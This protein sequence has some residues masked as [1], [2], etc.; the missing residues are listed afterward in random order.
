MIDAVG[1]IEGTLVNPESGKHFILTGAQKAF[2]RRAFEVAPDG[3]LKY[4]ELIFSAPKKTGK[5]AF[6]AFV[7]L[8]VVCVLGGRFAEGI[9]CANDEEQ[10]QGRVF[11]A[12][13]RITEASPTLKGDATITAS[14]ITFASTGS[15]IIAIA[16]DYAGAPEPIRRSP[17]LT[18]CGRTP[19]SAVIDFLTN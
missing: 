16:S 10:A 15:T 19:A 17:A 5:T 2:L 8:Y 3:R 4:P 1:F 12:V 13:S 9:C 6:A 7:V 14:K 11:Q 18:S